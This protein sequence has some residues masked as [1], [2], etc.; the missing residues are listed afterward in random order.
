LVLN[1]SAG[2]P[3]TISR[4]LQR[5][6]FA[7]VEADSPE[8]ALRACVDLCPDIALLNLQLPD[9]AGLEL[10][11]EVRAART[12]TRP[13]ILVFTGSQDG[14][15]ALDVLDAGADAVTMPPFSLDDLVTVVH[16]LRLAT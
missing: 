4:A 11:Q 15:D 13:V 9:P 3:G 10:I 16:N 6:G 1:S 14:D 5:Q 2:F 12:G 8:Q 7:V